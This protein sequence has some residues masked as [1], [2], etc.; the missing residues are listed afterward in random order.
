MPKADTPTAEPLASVDQLEGMLS[1]YD[2]WLDL[3]AQGRGEEVRAEIEARAAYFR[4]L[5][6]TARATP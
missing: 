3:F 1:I 6:Q 4:A 2:G 5:I